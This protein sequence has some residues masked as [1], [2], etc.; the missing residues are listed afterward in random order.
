MKVVYFHKKSLFGVLLPTL[1]SSTTA[2]QEVIYSENGKL[3]YTLTIEP[4]IYNNTETGLAQYLIGS[5]GEVGFPTLLVK[6]GDEISITLVNNLR[7]EPCNMYL[8]PELWNQYHAVDRTN[9]HFHGLHIS[10]LAN[11]VET[12]IGPGQS[13][14]YDFTIP[15]E[16]MGGTHWYHPHVAGSSSLQAGG[17][18]AGMMIVQ[19]LPGDL[20]KEYADLPELQ[21][22]IQFFN[23]TYL[24]TD[25]A[26]DYT[27]RCRESCL[28]AENR[29][30]CYEFFFEDGPLQGS[31]STTISPDGLEYETTLINGVESPTIDMVG[32]QWYRIRMGK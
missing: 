19:D 28:P 8:V 27:Q 21:W 23:M 9:L 12:S 17:G 26:A 14:N 31:Y 30:L 24:Q 25:Y 4:V 2:E 32:D 13:Y 11:P 7:R 22:R 5:N 3:S 10:N 18:G 6:P 15:E 16:H 29:G 1:L 20:P